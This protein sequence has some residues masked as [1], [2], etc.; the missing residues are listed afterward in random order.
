M[1]LYH[2]KLIKELETALENFGLC[3]L[4]FS[5][6]KNKIAT[7]QIQ[8]T[9]KYGYPLH[10]EKK[11]GCGKFATMFAVEIWNCR[12]NIELTDEGL[13]ASYLIYAH[14]KEAHLA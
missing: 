7:A 3:I 11:V 5:R 8:D 9:R 1:V 10:K 14:Y 4:Q 2:I 13:V 6:N 12:C